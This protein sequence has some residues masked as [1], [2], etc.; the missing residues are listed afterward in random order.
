MCFNLLLFF[1]NVRRPPRSTR[2]NTLFPDTTLFRSLH[3]E[4]V[5]DEFTAAPD[6]AVG[7]PA[8]D[9]EPV[10]HVSQAVLLGMVLVVN[11]GILGL[12]PGETT[13]LGADRKSKRLNS[14]H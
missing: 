1:Y 12:L 5:G 9:D 6:V 4:P 10:A 13:L 8:G 3:L 11:A 2:T 14:S 7:D